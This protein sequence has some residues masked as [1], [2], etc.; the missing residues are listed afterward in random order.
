[1]RTDR[2]ALHHK[3][4]PGKIFPQDAGWI[5]GYQGRGGGASMGRTVGRKRCRCFYEKEVQ[6]EDASSLRVKEKEAG[7]DPLPGYQ[8]IITT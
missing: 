2:T 4:T 3:G 5:S 1:M 6:G 7:I 8:E